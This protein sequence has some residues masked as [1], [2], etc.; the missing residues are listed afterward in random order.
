MMEIF[1]IFIC[2]Y[3]LYTVEGFVELHISCTSLPS[4]ALHNIPKTAS[5]NLPTIFKQSTKRNSKKAKTYKLL[6]TKEMGSS[7]LDV[8]V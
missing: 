2:I 8:Q 6:E 3:V 1:L 5:I 7:S 4:L